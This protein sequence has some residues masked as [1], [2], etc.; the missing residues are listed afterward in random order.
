MKRSCN[1]EASGAASGRIN[2]GAPTIVLPAAGPDLRLARKAQAIEAIWDL[3]HQ[4]ERLLLGQ[5]TF[6]TNDI[7]LIRLQHNRPHFV[8]DLEHAFDMVTVPLNVIMYEIND[9]AARLTD[10]SLMA[11]IDWFDHLINWMF[12]SDLTNAN[13]IIQC[14]NE[15]LAAIARFKAFVNEHLALL[16][17]PPCP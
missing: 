8:A 6:S 12:E 17:R 11:V 4:L 9:Q 14:A 1:G 7:N 16:N 3:N 15:A 10:M 2:I 13:A 5:Y